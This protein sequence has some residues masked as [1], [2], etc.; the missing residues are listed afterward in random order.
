MENPKR[1]RSGKPRIQPRGSTCVDPSG[2]QSA[3]ERIR[4]AASRDKKLRF[5]GLWHHV[6]EVNRLRDAYSS[7]KRGAAPGIDGETWQH[8]GETLEE[9]LQ[10]LSGRLERGAYRAKP[11]KRAYIP[12]ADGRQRPLGVTVLEDKVAQRATAEVVGCQIILI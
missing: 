9:N 7:L 12:K 10:D 8:Y 3:L 4:Q 1:A 6:Y 2:L 5:T 11:V